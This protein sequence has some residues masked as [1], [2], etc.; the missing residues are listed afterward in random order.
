MVLTAEPDPEFERALSGAGALACEREIDG[1]SEPPGTATFLG[2]PRP[3]SMVRRAASVGWLEPC[4]LSVE[5][6]AEA[7][8]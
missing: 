2:D 1:S 8:P 3:R 4:C 5:P 7:W 6:V